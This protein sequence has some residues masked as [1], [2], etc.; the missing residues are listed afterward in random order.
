LFFFCFFFAEPPL[1][2]R[3]GELGEDINAN[4]IGYWDRDLDSK[5]ESSY[6]EKEE[7]EVCT[8]L[9]VGV[10]GNTEGGV[11]LYLGEGE[12]I[13]CVIVGDR[14][15]LGDKYRV[16]GVGVFILE[17]GGGESVLLAFF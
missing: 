2:R 5:G 9:W 8:L 16:V 15:P 3:R 4:Y 13:Y 7:E 10:P 14:A 17:G 1:K 12:H 11:F 6:S